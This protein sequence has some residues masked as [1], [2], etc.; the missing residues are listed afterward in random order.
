MLVLSR[1]V[2]EVIMI[3]D[4]ISVM[5]I[6]VRGDKVR[7]GVQAPRHIHVNR[8]EIHIS[9]KSEG[10]LTPLEPPYPPAG[11]FHD[12]WLTQD[13]NGDIYWWDSKPT[14]HGEE[15]VSSSSWCCLIEPEMFAWAFPSSMPFNQRCVE[16]GPRAEDFR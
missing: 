4:E 11:F 15:W 10:N 3:G 13:A 6:E 8:A 7:L 14:F 2:N 16:V 9:K 5:V 12:G 1:R